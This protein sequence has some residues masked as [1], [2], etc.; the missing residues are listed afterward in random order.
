MTHSSI[1]SSD[2]GRALD[3]AF[4]PQ[5]APSMVAAGGIYLFLKVPGEGGGAG[6]VELVA[7]RKKG[8]LLS[9]R[10]EVEEGV[11]AKFGHLREFQGGPRNSHPQLQASWNNTASFIFQR[12]FI[13]FKPTD[14]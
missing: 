2:C 8:I 1:L 13:H 6:R 9:L 12:S 7:E 11:S 4:F 3:P 5:P 10:A 14:L